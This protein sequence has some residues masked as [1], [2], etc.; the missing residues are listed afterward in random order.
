MYP[1]WMSCGMLYLEVRAKT[2]AETLTNIIFR[3]FDKVCY[4]GRLKGVSK[5]VQVVL[6]GRSSF[7]LALIMFLKSYRDPQYGFRNAPEF[8]AV[9]SCNP[10]RPLIKI[11]L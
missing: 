5:S 7:A 6:N 4:L 10:L 2:E 9:G 11:L 3:S 1:G 8:R